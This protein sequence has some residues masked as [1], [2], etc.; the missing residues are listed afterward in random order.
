[1]YT[2]TTRVT[3]RRVADISDDSRA[4]R[5]DQGY[6]CTGIREENGETREEEGRGGGGGEARG[7]G[8]GESGSLGKVAT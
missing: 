7:G 1:M 6:K 2:H 4:H 3:D 8:L 5:I